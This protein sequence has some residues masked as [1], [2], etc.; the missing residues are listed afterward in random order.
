ME[1]TYI[2]KGKIDDIT[3]NKNWLQMISHKIKTGWSSEKTTVGKKRKNELEPAWW[4]VRTVPMC[5]VVQGEIFQVE[6]SKRWM[7][8]FFFFVNL[9]VL[10]YLIRFSGLFFLHRPEYKWRS[11]L[12]FYVELTIECYSYKWTNVWFIW[13][14]KCVIHSFMKIP[15]I[16]SIFL[17]W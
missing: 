15:F 12:H 10:N 17:K 5:A 11:C 16:I 4:S 8:D 2:L 7:T 6:N 9:V 3:Q 13:F 14:N 1:L